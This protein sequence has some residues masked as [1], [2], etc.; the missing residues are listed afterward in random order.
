MPALDVTALLLELPPRFTL[1]L[2]VRLNSI[3]PMQL[4]LAFYM[5]DVSACLILAL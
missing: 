1:R 5:T 3:N 4:G 2:L